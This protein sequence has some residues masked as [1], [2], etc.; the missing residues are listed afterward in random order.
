MNDDILLMQVILEF[1]SLMDQIV[2]SLWQSDFADHNLAGECIFQI[3]LG[4]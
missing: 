3:L 1:F 4:I 2:K